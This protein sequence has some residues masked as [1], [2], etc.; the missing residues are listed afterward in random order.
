[1]HRVTALRKRWLLDTYQG[2]VSNRH[3]DYCLDEF[4]FRFNRRTSGLCG[5]LL[6]ATGAS[7]PHRRLG[8]GRAERAVG[9]HP[10]QTCVMWIVPRVILRSSPQ[11]PNLRTAR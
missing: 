2:A 10:E 3:L 4:T 8:S 9:V 6:C 7:K 1:M 5:L 11:Q